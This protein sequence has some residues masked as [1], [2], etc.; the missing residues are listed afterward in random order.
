MPACINVLR[1]CSS[2]A[3]SDFF[4]ATLEVLKMYDTLLE[5]GAEGVYVM[6]FYV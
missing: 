4:N 2:S 3:F 1:M 5:F 6:L